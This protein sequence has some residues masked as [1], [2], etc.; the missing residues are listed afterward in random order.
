MSVHSFTIRRQVITQYGVPMGLDFCEHCARGHHGAS[1]EEECVDRLPP[2][3][4][5]HIV[6]RKV[7]LAQGMVDLGDIRVRQGR[8]LRPRASKRVLA[9]WRRE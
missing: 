3:S 1:Q 9:T 4:V 7:K 8:R 5:A 2:E 6:D